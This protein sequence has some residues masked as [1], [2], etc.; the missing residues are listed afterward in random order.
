MTRSVGSSSTISTRAMILDPLVQDPGGGSGWC[1]QERYRQ[2]LQFY[3]NMRAPVKLPDS[4]V[5]NLM[6]PVPGRGEGTHY[7]NNSAGVLDQMLAS[8][9]VLVQSSPIRVQPNTI[10][11]VRFPA[12]VNTGTYSSPIRFGRGQNPNI[13]GFSDH[14]SIAVQVVES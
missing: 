9:G 14:F 2:Y 12:H 11:V 6:W 4:L 5:L 1:E 3:C 10:E 13:N 8:R 7:Y